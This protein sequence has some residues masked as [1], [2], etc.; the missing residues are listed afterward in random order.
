MSVT[1]LDGEFPMKRMVLAAALVLAGACA[2]QADTNV[3]TN[4][5]KHARSDAQTR[6]D[7][8]ACQRIVGPDLNGVPTSRAMKRCMARRG[9]RF[10]YTRREYTWI[11]PDTGLRCHNADIA[12][13]CSNF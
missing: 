11:D 13:V 5:T 10:E 4:T 12:C 6:A 9:W 2:A 1:P 7:A 8:A 3:W